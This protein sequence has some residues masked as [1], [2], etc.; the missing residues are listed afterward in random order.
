MSIKAVEWAFKEGP[1]NAHDLLVLV[2]LAEYADKHGCCFP[3]IK[4]LA[5]KCRMSERGVQNSVQHLIAGGF[6]VVERGGWQEGS[7]RYR[8]VKQSKVGGAPDA[9]L[10]PATDAPPHPMHP[11]VNPV[12]PGGEPGAPK[13]SENRKTKGSPSEQEAREARAVLCAVFSEGVA[14]D[15]IAHRKAKRAKMTLKAAELIAKDFAGISQEAA[16]AAALKSI[17]QGWTGVF[18]PAPNVIPIH[19][20]SSAKGKTNGQAEGFRIALER[21]RARGMD[22]G[23]GD[24][25]A[26]PLLPA[27]R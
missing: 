8:L 10:P 4:T 14:D 27:G 3:S 12:H 17:K 18:P 19:P 7:N 25:P 9:P 24:D 6:L 15:Y 26:V 22:F 23:P 2:A 16:D 5:T 21:R 20:H 13:P 11:P 1:D